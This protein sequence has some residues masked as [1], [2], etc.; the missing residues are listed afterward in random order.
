[1]RLDC[2]AIDPALAHPTRMTLAEALAVRAAA[3]QEP[4]A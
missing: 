2:P 3:V 4:V 1:V